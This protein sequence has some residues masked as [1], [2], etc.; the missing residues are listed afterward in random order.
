M[1]FLWAVVCGPQF[2]AIFLLTEVVFLLALQAQTEKLCEGVYGQ[3]VLKGIIHH[4][5][6]SLYSTSCLLKSVWVS[7]SFIW[8]LM[9]LFIGQWLERVFM[10]K[11]PTSSEKCTFC[12][13]RDVL[14]LAQIVRRICRFL[15]Y[16]IILYL[17]FACWMDHVNFVGCTICFSSCTNCFK[18]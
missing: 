17:F 14:T 13:L 10:I 15:L 1:T 12:I 6:K 16:D 9:E 3:Y 18:I 7:F 8:T 11:D 5:I 2:P 4:K